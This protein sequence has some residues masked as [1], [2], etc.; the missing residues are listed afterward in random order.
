MN[1]TLISHFL[2]EEELLP[3]WLTHHKKLFTHGI[4]LDCGSIDNSCKI[5]KEICPTWEI[6]DFSKECICTPNIDL[7]KVE[8]IES[9]L[10]GWKC[11]LN[12][13]EYLIIDDLEKYI[14]NFELEDPTSVGFKV[15]SVIIVD[16]T[17]NDQINS[18]ANK[19]FGYI[20]AGK[21]WAGSMY[22]YTFPVV[23]HIS[24]RGRLVHKNSTGCYIQGRHET[25][26]AVKVRNDIFL[27]WIGRGL[28]ELYYKRC[29][30]WNQRSCTLRLARYDD[31][32]EEFCYKFW[33]NEVKKSE[34]L[35]E[36]LPKYKEYIDTL[37]T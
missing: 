31:V 20:E 5:I 18:I 9:T 14:K 26:L 25:R 33:K 16:R 21:A 27:A 10:T 8:E 34:N 4:M 6:I 24:P 15:T 19:D 7:Y 22:D 28:P 30:K 3:S 11:I 23:P 29:Q 37:Y 17:Y 2:S 13:G 36:L 12:V 1:R 32:T 35:F